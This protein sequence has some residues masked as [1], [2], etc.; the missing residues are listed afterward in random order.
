MKDETEAVTE[1]EWLVRRITAERFKRGRD[2][3]SPNAFEPRIKGR[4]ID[5]DGISLYR[6]SCLSDATE[7]LSI[8]DPA[9][10]SG[11]GLVRVSVRVIKSLNLTVMIAPDIHVRGHVVIPQMNAADYKAHKWWFE[12]I[13]RKL[14]E[15]ASEELNI[16]RYPTT[17]TLDGSEQPAGF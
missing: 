7:V 15:E 17:S 8:V 12:P 11:I 9:K 6:L 3:H 4:E 14:A 2:P 10:W 1:D 5:E 13:K 16:I